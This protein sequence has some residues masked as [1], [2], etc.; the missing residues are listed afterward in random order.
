MPL[1]KICQNIRFLQQVYSGKKTEIFD[2]ALQEKI[3]VKENM[4]FS[5]VHTACNFDMSLCNF[6]KIIVM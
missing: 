4:Y 2:S 1:H 3:G 6:F 5:T